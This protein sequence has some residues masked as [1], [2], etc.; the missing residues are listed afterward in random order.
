MDKGGDRLALIT[1]QIK[2]LDE[3][4][5]PKACDTPTSTHHS[6]TESSPPIMVSQDF[7][8][9]INASL[10]EKANLSKMVKMRTISPTT[11]VPDP[12]PKTVEENTP[13][14]TTTTTT[15]NNTKEAS[16]IVT[17]S[18]RDTTPP[19][20][21]TTASVPPPPPPAA[22]NSI[23]SSKRITQGIIFSEKPRA[24][25][26]M[27]IGLL[28]FIMSK[29]SFIA[30]RPFYLILLS[31]VTIVIARLFGEEVED[32]RAATGG[33]GGKAADGENWDDAF[34][35]LERGLVFYQATK[36][37]FVDSSI[38]LVVVIFGLSLTYY[39]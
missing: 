39:L 13:D 20:A 7:L 18:I 26:S 33:G 29:E 14:T 17:T 31:D 22:S 19:V 23:F 35:L 27:I 10:E 38:Y 32:K 6:H 37:I 8:N 28:V 9:S 16:E 5:T 25:C 1:G 36:A 4:V 2:N 3:S 30:S 11:H 15:T 34:K 12:V 24:I 21:A